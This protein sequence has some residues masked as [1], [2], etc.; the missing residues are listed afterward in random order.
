[1]GWAAGHIEQLKLGEIA[2]FRPRGNSM[3]GKIDSG[4]LVTVQPLFEDEAPAV[5]EIV[6]CKVKGREFLHLVKAVRD[7]QFQ[8][9][10]NKGFI[11]GWTSRAQIF[12]RVV[13]VEK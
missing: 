5:G 12:G 10:N 11:N 3:T 1:M 13:K 8:I 6:L 2:K 9:G 7:D 4:D